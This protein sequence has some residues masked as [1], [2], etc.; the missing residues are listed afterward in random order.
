M[1][2]TLEQSTIRRGVPVRKAAFFRN[3]FVHGE[4]V[5]AGD[6]GGAIIGCPLFREAPP[7]DRAVVPPNVAVFS[8]TRTSAPK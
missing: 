6:E 2:G 1:D 7:P 3:F 4:Q 8:T 5:E